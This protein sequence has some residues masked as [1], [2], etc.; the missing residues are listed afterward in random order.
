M[1]IRND[2]SSQF[3]AQKVRQTLQYLEAQQEFTHV[4]MPQENAYIKAFHSR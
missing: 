3:I 1:I 4:A 2:N